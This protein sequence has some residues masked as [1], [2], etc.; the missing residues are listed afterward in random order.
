MLRGLYVIAGAGVI[1][2][3]LP[4]EQ[5]AR[6]EPSPQDLQPPTFRTGVNFVR[7]DVVASEKDGRQVSNLKAEDFEITEEG[8]RQ[9]IETFKLITLDGG[10]DPGLEGAPTR[11]SSSAVEEEEAARDDIRM[12]AIFL[13]DYHVSP[14]GGRNVREQVARFVETQLGPSDLVGLMYPLTSL[15]SVQMSRNRDAASKTIREFEGR[16][17]VIAP[18]NVFEEN[19]VYR[20]GN[21]AGIRRDVSFSAI[22]GLIMRMGGLKEGRKTL[23]LVSEGYGGGGSVHQ[24]LREI[25]ELASRNNTAIYPVT[26]QLYRPA[27]QGMP[28]TLTDGMNVLAQHSGGRLIYEAARNMAELRERRFSVGTPRSTLA[29]VMGQIIVDSSAYYLLGYN[30]TR[31]AP[32]GKF[33]KIEV[34]AKRP[35]IQL[36]Y[37][38]GYFASR[39]EDLTRATPARPPAPLSVVETALA[40]GAAPRGRPVRTWI[41]M[42]RGANGH[43]RVTVAWE[44]LPDVPGS[45]LKESERPVSLLLKA[46]GSATVSY[47]EGRVPETVVD[48]VAG[49]HATFEAPP[50]TIQL[51]LSLV[52]AA[53]SVLDT[54]VRNLA[55]RDLTA[56]GLAVGTPE[57]FRARTVPELQ[58]L[59]SAVDPTPV[60]ARE[61]SRTERLLLR[62]P[63]YAPE[64]VRP[65]LGAQ[66]L[67]RAGQRM[68]ELPVTPPETSGGSF[69]IEVPLAG[70]PAGAYGVR[71]T[72]IVEGAE[73][74]EIVA[75]RVT[76]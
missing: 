64:E 49:A 21:V 20:T 13:D 10:R 75:F 34:K 17:G 28:L 55:V 14:S 27:S 31:T 11:I 42:E 67:N 41:G 26:P 29:S 45:T 30:S 4:V 63:V 35:G 16:R 72:A 50:G 69:G 7:V 71:I 40:A 73:A 38:K 9:K 43:T 25:A 44:P 68:A 61:F 12:F 24:E 33:H 23:I 51:R 5:A 62:V 58:R 18:K 48:R 15:A 6:Q 54:E 36:R 57:V 1:T 8:K 2:L 52:N 70:L 59:K 66:L 46:S 56:P 37:R 60:V 76:N 19:Y 22:R 47:F 39:S 65:S 53:G 32:D 3:L 74:A